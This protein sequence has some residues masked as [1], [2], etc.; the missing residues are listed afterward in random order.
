MHALVTLVLLNALLETFSSVYSEV[1]LTIISF[2]QKLITGGW[3]KS[4]GLE[5][6]AQSNRGA[7]IQYLRVLSSAPSF[8]FD[9]NYKKQAAQS[10][11]IFSMALFG[12][13]L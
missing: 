8:Q 9:E 7:I 12:K 10:S 13:A 3:N 1:L 6:F 4:R 2:F 11:F 5:N